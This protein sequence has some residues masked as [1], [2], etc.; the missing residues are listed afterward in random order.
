MSTFAL[1]EKYCGF[2]KCFPNIYLFIYSFASLQQNVY[3]L[4]GLGWFVTYN[5][6]LCFTVGVLMQC[7]ARSCY[8]WAYSVRVN[9]LSMFCF[10]H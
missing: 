10:Y 6:S 9:E 3:I 7:A 1:L 8:V 5:W 2:K 4:V